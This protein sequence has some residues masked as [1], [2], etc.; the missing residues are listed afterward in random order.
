MKGVACP[1]ALS[2]ERAG[3]V[4]RDAEMTVRLEG[5]SKLVTGGQVVDTGRR[6]ARDFVFH[7][8][9]EKLSNSYFRVI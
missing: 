7:E 2:Q 9:V 6:H 4:Q 3:C 8:S 1:K 5:K